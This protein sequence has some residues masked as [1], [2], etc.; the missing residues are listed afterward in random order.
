VL[1]AAIVRFV[2]EEDAQDLIEYALLIAFLALTVCVGL[3]AFGA[4]INDAFDGASSCVDGHGHGRGHA[5]GWGR[6][7]C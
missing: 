5:Y 7:H 2:R 6:A 3:Q 4:N 1:I